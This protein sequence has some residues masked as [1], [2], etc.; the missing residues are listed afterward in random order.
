M[1][2]CI[3]ARSAWRIARGT[4][5]KPAAGRGTVSTKSVGTSCPVGVGVEVGNGLGLLVVVGGFGVG[6]GLGGPTDEHDTIVEVT[7]SAMTTGW[8]A[9]WMRA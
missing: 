2:A 5:E 3:G 1:V 7:N 8:K 9:F 6:V 4:N